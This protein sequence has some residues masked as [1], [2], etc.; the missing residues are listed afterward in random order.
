MRDVDR[1]DRDEDDEERDDVHDRAARRGARSVAKIQIGSVCCG[2]GGEDRHDHLVEREREREQR[3]RRAAPSASAGASRSGT[4]ARCRRRGR[5]TP[6]RASR[7]YG[8]CRAIDVVVDDDD[9][10]GRVA[11]DDRR[12]AEADTRCGPRTSRIVACSARPVTIPG[13]AIGRMTANVI[14]SRPKKSV[15]R[16]R[17][18]TASVPSTSAIAVAPRAA[19]IEF[20]SASRTSSS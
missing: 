13:S 2:A 16:R 1:D 15:A 19:R 6:R 18:A 17:R 9:A 4:S 14:T 10:E 7:P 3:L 5:P 12:E 11:D 8:A 20:L